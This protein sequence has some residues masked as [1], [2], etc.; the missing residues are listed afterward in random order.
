MKAYKSIETI[1]RKCTYEEF[2]ERLKKIENYNI[3]DGKGE[4]PLGISA[5]YGHLDACDY[6][7]NN[8]G[9]INIKNGDGE[10]AL[11]SA[12]NGY[13]TNSGTR[14]I[15]VLKFLIKNGININAANKDGISPIMK[16][17]RCNT[18]VENIPCLLLES[19]IDLTHKTNWGKTVLMYASES[20]NLKL[21]TKLLKKGVDIHAIDDDGRNALYYAAKYHVIESDEYL[22]IIGLLLKNSLSLNTHSISKQ[23]NLIIASSTNGYIPLI[24]QCIDSGIDINA[25]DENG[26]TALILAC[27][28]V[29]KIETIKLLL[30]NGVKPNIKN[31]ENK[32]AINYIDDIDSNKD[33]K[34]LFITS[35]AIIDAE[36]EIDK[37]S[38]T[39]LM[40]LCKSGTNSSIMKI[41]QLLDQG[42]NVNIQDKYGKTALIYLLDNNYYGDFVKEVFELLLNIKDI[43]LNLQTKTGMTALMYVCKLTLVDINYIKK[44]I[45]SGANVNLVNT[46][47]KTALS[48]VKYPDELIENLLS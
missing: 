30:E 36:L 34:N 45:Q 28:G 1:L 33:L 27:L 21:V 42:V 43:N 9:N 10:S 48:F 38:M 20:G 47:N 35:G 11:Y 4:S 12:I 25:Q 5:Y 29:Q 16:S 13:A 40:H 32:M 6:I 3:L 46:K 17:T 37:N 18:H 15:D 22:K 2:L 24:K 31:K 26:N 39:K 44:L 14:N 7:L 23:D 8:G 19:N 41:R